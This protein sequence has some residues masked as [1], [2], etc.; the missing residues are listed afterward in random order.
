MRT[1]ATLLLAAVLAAGVTLLTGVDVGAAEPQ[2]GPRSCDTTTFHVDALPLGGTEFPTTDCVNNPGQQCV[3]YGYRV[4]TK[5]TNARI[6]KAIFAVSVDQDV[7]STSSTPASAP[8]APP[9]VSAPGAGES[10]TQFLLRSRHEY[11]VRFLTPTTNVTSFDAH[12]LIVAPSTPRTTTIL[13][14]SLS[15]ALESC[16][17]AGPGVQVQ[18][19]PFKPQLVQQD[20]TCAGGACMC[21]LNFD[22]AGNLVSVTADP[23]VQ[24]ATCVATLLDQQL[25][26]D[27][28]DGQGPQQVQHFEQITSGT[29][30]CTTYNTK[31]KKT[32]ICR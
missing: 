19:D 17:I 16:L 22:A 27:L 24:G 13:M 7:D 12:M 20:T 4:R 26:I 21:H 15:G 11:T 28:G 18:V 10:T 2:P 30:T 1:S 5:P 23:L 3:D 32:T 29:G 14:R 6:N 9:V 8:S 31:P 25:F